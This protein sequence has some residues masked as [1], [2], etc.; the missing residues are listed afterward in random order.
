MSVISWNYRGL[1]SLSAIPNLKF[2]FLYYKQDTLFLSETLVF[3]NKIE[4]FRYILGSDN[5][6][7][8][9]RQGRGG[10]LALFWHNSLIVVSL[11]FHKII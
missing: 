2:L 3:R 10:G 8:V 11:I 6:F 5:Y 1:R 7:V 9:D 4:E